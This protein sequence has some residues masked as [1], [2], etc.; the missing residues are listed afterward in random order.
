MAS[1]SSSTSSGSTGDA[2]GQRGSLSATLG[3]MLAGVF[4]AS[5]AASAGE[6]EDGLH[7]PSYPWPHEGIFDSYDHASIRRGHQVYQQ[8]GARGSRKECQAGASGLYA[9]L[10]R[11]FAH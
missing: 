5:V 1:S 4:G 10:G 7:A 2:A 8:V 9:C 11:R 6:V 3:G